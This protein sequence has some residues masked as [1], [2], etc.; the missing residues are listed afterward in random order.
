MR[1][2]GIGV[3][4]RGSAAVC[5]HGGISS[6]R[7]VY[8][9]LR[10]PFAF[11]L[12]CVQSSLRTVGLLLRTGLR[13]ALIAPLLMPVRLHLLH[14][15][16]FLP[17][18]VRA[19][20]EPDVRHNPFG[21]PMGCGR[22]GDVGEGQEEFAV[23]RAAR[24]FPV[25]VLRRTAPTRPI[26]GVANHAL[27]QLVLQKANGENVVARGLASIPIR[28][29]SQLCVGFGKFAVEPFKLLAVFCQRL[30]VRPNGV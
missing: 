22:I 13:I 1:D 14:E 20:I 27:V 8:D 12:R 5:R 28:R 30:R 15:Q 10:H 9:L 23:V 25:L 24:E 21:I 3:P 2:L 6:V 26:Q 17:L 18:H 4:R 16:G 19:R 29:A 7:G 11:G